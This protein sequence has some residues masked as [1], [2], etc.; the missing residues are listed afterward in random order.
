M[1]I[2]SRSF[3][4]IQLPARARVLWVSPAWAVVCGLI[5]SA[6]FTWTGRDV[7]LAALALVLA[8][9]AWA[10][11][12][13]GL[14]ETDWRTIFSGWQSFQVEPVASALVERGSPADRSQ[15]LWARWHMWWAAGGREQGGTPLFSALFAAVLALLL[16]IVIGG[17]AVALTLAALALIQIAL[18]LRLH[19]HAAYWLRG[20]IDIGFAWWLGQLIFGALTLPAMI[21]A[22]LFASSY[23]ALLDLAQG[24]AG[25]RRWLLPQLIIVVMLIVLQQPSAAL[26]LTAVLIAQTTLSTV[27]NGLDFARAAQFW[28][29]LAMLITA[30]G[31]R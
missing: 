11:V 17:E 27:L 2:E 25:L 15:H 18:I 20:L 30:L 1:N 5:A 31:I 8:D 16:S 3:L 14:A 28:L 9:S 24:R 21:G 29:M 10:S 4:Q 23:A 26:A 6:A 22:L 13:G 12:W 19:G 7:L